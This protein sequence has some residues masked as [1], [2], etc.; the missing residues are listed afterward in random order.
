VTPLQ[1][2]VLTWGGLAAAAYLAYEYFAGEV[3]SAANAID[4]LNPNNV[5]NTAANAVVAA[6]PG[7]D[8]G[9]TIGTDIYSATH[10][11][12]VQSPGATPVEVSEL[13]Y[14]ANE[15]N[16]FGDTWTIVNGPTGTANPGAAVVYVAPGNG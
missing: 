7:A 11:W 4:P 3:A 14:Y 10:V 9:G 1:K 6:V 15:M 13:D 12:V 16:P 5:F 2:N 8:S